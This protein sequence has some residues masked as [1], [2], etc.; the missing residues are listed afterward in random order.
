[1]GCA[2]ILT[3]LWGVDMDIKNVKVGENI[4]HIPT[5]KVYYYSGIT[6]LKQPEG[7]WVDVHSYNDYGVKM[8]HRFE[9][10]FDSF[11]RYDID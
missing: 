8:F 2:L 9:G 5:G 3:C 1:M 11:E 4:R 7:G 10:D 6:R